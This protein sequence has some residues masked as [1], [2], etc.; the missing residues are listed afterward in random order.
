MANDLTLNNRQMET[1]FTA[2]D[3]IRRG[4]TG[5]NRAYRG[6]RDYNVVL[7]YPEVITNEQYDYWYRRSGLAARIIEQPC[8]DTWK[9]PPPVTSASE[10]FVRA[11]ETVVSKNRVWNALSRA[12]RLSGIGEYGVLLL[13]FKTDSP[14]KAPVRKGELNALGPKGLLYLRPF[15]AMAADVSRMDDNRSS[16]RYGLPLTYAIDVDGEHS[17]E[18][19][20]SR[21]LHIADGK[22]DSEVR[23]TP[24]LRKVFNVLLDTMKVA[25]G[26]PE[27][28]WLEMR[29]GLIFKTMEGYRKTGDEDDET[30]QKQQM[31]E[32]VHDLARVL[33][34]EGIEPQNLG[35]QIPDPSGVWTML[36]EILSVSTGIPQRILFGSAAG[37]L[38]SAEEDT[39]QWYSIVGDRQTNYAEPEILRPFIE[40]LKGVGILPPANYEIGVP[41]GDGNLSWPALFEMSDL[42]KAQVADI[43][44]SAVQKLSNPATGQLPLTEDEVRSI[45]GLDPL[46]DGTSNLALVAHQANKELVDYHCP[47]C[48]A[49]QAYRYDGHPPTLLV[50]AGCG[51]TIDTEVE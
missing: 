2:L 44:A 3:S 51:W 34:L 50:C 13:G 19:H 24:R 11:W 43:K 35:S 28:A 31:E 26:V 33:F 36:K 47:H 46:E 45:L 32:F 23:G 16:A 17:Q 15:S 39:Q 40:R 7:G 1:L 30:G 5:Q 8:I 41:D 18:V 21:V 14:L 49:D 42:D 9:K 22:T 27:A 25:G 37:A 10:E 29:R 4:I 48:N 12:D 20:W 38:A 6:A